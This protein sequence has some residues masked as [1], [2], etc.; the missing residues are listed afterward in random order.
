MKWKLL[1]PFL[2]FSFL[3]TTMLVYI[4]LS[5]QQD[6]IKREERKEIL[7]FYHLFLTRIVHKGDQA[8]SMATIVAQDPRV[9]G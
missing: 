1:I 9:K 7:D 2:M 4:G 6:L 5:S 8:L 3:G